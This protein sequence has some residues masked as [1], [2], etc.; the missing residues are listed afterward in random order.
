MKEGCG[1][2]A[3]NLPLPEEP[4]FSRQIYIHMSLKRPSNIDQMK[5]FSCEHYVKFSITTYMQYT[6]M[7]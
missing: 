7:Q 6:Y 3:I 2:L 5:H 4:L 1:W